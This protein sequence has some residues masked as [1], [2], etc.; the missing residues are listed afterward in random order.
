MPLARGG[1]PANSTDF[2]FLGSPADT[3]KVPRFNLP[4]TDCTSD[5]AALTTAVLTTVALPLNAGDLVT[6]L[7]V[8]S[9]ATAAGTPTNYWVALY[10]LT[11]TLISQSA[12]QTSTAWA[13]NTTKDLA[14]ATPYYVVT[15]GVYYAGIMVKA[16]TPPTLIGVTLG[17]A[18][19]STGVL[20]TDKILSQTSGS[21]LTT[22]AP[23]TIAT[24]TA[25]AAVPL[26]VAH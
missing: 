26:V 6:K 21:A 11:G 4:R 10:D 23:A 9:G 3:S 2:L 16:T 7:A 24:P 19:A 15:P 17:T 1:Y 18:G 13:A 22:T 14:L 25:I 12:D 5:T 8:K 20:S